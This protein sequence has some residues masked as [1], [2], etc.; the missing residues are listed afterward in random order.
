MVRAPLPPDLGRREGAMPDAQF[1]CRWYDVAMAVLEGSAQSIA[2]LDLA[3]DFIARCPRDG[4]LALARAIAA[5]QIWRDMDGR[6]PIFQG[7]RGVNNAASVMALY[8]E[9]MAFPST[10]LEAHVRAAWLAYR[11]GEFDRALT[12]L[13]NGPHETADPVL[14][15]FWH[16]VG[17]QTLRKLNRGDQAVAEYRAASDVF[18]GAQAARVGL[19]TLFIERGD[20]PAAEAL[21]TTVETAPDTAIDPWWVYWQGDYRSY[22]SGLAELRRLAEAR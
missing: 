20:R 19:M 18:P 4:R 9:A 6:A 5:D 1:E 14:G 7:P 2:V 16:L 13:E 3:P 22:R 12:L 11:G 10:A 21:A 17:A 8:E 15:Y